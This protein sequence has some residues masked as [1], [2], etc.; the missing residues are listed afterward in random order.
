MM[1]AFGPTLN[2]RSLMIM[3][4]I[5]FFRPMIQERKLSSAKH[6]DPIIE[7]IKEVLGV[8]VTVK[9]VDENEIIK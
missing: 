8:D 3:L 6:I 4:P 7:A 5:L 9:I 2:V 1:H